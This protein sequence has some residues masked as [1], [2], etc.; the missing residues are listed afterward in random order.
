MRLVE[1]VA[2]AGDRQQDGSH[3]DGRRC[4]EGDCGDLAG[5]E[6]WDDEPSPRGRGKPRDDELAE[7]C[8][9][10]VAGE[11][12]AGGRSCGAGLGG[13]GDGQ[14]VGDRRR[15]RARPRSAGSGCGAA[16]WR[17]DSGGRSASR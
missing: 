1:G 12:R 8:A 4:Q 14:T 9:G 11:Q 10:R 17:R 13:V 2:G 7:Y 16:W 5:D 6:K 15:T 3:R